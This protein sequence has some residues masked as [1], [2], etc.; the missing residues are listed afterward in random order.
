MTWPQRGMSIAHD[1]LGVTTATE[2]R[3]RVQMHGEIDGLWL[4]VLSALE[5][6]IRT[7]RLVTA[8]EPVPGA[9]A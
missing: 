5:E 1:L 4:L 3:S 7:I 6:D 8:G 2:G 9:S